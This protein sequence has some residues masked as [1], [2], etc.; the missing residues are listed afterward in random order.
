M[1]ALIVPACKQE[2]EEPVIPNYVFAT[3]SSLTMVEGSDTTV[4]LSGGIPPY[5]ILQSP[6]ANIASISLSDA[7]V[8]I[9]SAL[10]S[11]TDKIRIGDSAP[12]QNSVT[13]PIVVF[14]PP[15]A[16]VIHQH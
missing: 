5:T 4:S 13:V 15:L 14:Q 2:N 12:S 1:A 10:S 9:H 11:G 7:T 8:H 3:P 16:Q 6:K